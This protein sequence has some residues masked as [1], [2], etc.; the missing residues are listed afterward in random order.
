MYAGHNGDNCIYTGLLKERHIHLEKHVDLG[1]TTDQT[2]LGLSAIVFLSVG[3][4]PYY[5]SPN[6]SI[7]KSSQY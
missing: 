4:Y 3:H 2:L 5:E 7:I 1:C 6:F